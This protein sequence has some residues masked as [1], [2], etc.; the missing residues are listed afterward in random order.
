MLNPLIGRSHRLDLCSSE[1]FVVDVRLQGSGEF[2]F[3]GSFD[4]EGASVV[5]DL[6]TDTPVSAVVALMDLVIVHTRQAYVF[7]KPISFS[8]ALLVATFIEVGRA[9]E[10]G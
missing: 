10:S 8:V 6:D 2:A 7:E 1:R 9:L 4:P 3:V 5:L